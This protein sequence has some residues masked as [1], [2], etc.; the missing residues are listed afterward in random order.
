MPAIRLLNG[1][2]VTPGLAT[3]LQCARWYTIVKDHGLGFF[4]SNVLQARKRGL[5][6]QSTGQKTYY[7]PKEGVIHAN[8]ADKVCRW[9]ENRDILRYTSCTT[10]VSRFNFVVSF[11]IARL[12][13]PS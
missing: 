7:A 8:E 12:C 4:L 3:L 5:Q 13:C 2:D 11:C 1:V 10:F 6:C 9:V